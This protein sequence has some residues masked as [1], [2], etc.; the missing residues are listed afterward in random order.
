MLA[1][2]TQKADRL[3]DL[4]R[5]DFREK[6]I[7]PEQAIPQL[8]RVVSAYKS[9][10]VDE[11][12]S[13]TTAL[14][15]ADLLKASQSMPESIYLQVVDEVTRISIGCE[16]ILMNLRYKTPYVFQVG[17]NGQVDQVRNFCAIGSG[18]TNAESWLHYRA[19]SPYLP[20][21]TSVVSVYE[22]KK[23]AEHAPGVSKETKLMIMG[24]Y[25]RVRFL[26][27]F[28]TLDGMW[29]TYGPQTH[30][31]SQ[32]VGALKAEDYMDTKWENVI[33]D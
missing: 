24:P 16:L 21:A 11:Y 30:K 27:S 7:E 32:L 20:L 12:T 28:S 19:Q 1:G 14:S 2:D 17:I 13:N 10:L 15:Y 31:R 9:E 33:A 6:R 5:F 25:D 8:R 4:L 18:A 23:F 22:A 3:L 29:S 26:Q